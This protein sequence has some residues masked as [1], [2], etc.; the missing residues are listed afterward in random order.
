M[1]HG[2]EITHLRYFVAVAEELHFGR[3]ATRLAISQPPLTQ[4]IQRLEERI[5]FALL[6]R[7]TRRTE[8]TEAGAALLVRARAVLAELDRAVEAARAAGRGETGELVVGTPPSVM[9][10]GLPNVIRWF[11]RQM[12]GVELRLRELSTAAIME[13]LQGGALDVGFLR[14]PSVAGDLRELFRF[15]EGVAVVMAR[16]HRLAAVRR[17]RLEQ[18][19]R[20]PFVSFPRRLGAGFHD[21]LWEMC[22][23]AGFEP[24]VVQ[25]ATQWSTVVA[26]VEAG[27]G[28]TIGPASIARLGVRGCVAR[29]LPGRTTTVL[30]ACGPQR[31]KAAG[32]RFVEGCRTRF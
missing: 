4:Q 15:S 2:I 21:E 5:G 22:R 32:E 6:D 23:S 11:R 8:L 14:A 1:N 3:A 26:L 24:N 30:L 28:V 31:L 7:S 19:A 13:G 10:A 29:V 16:H 18:L 17:L 20:E 9:L 27:L 25:E 12:Q